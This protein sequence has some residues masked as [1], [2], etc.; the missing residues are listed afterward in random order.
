LTVGRYQKRNPGIVQ[1]YF[2]EPQISVPK[3]SL[4]NIVRA[5]G[6]SDDSLEIPCGTN[7]Q[8]A[9]NATGVNFTVSDHRYL[10]L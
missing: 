1:I 4:S 8:I 7:T 9:M 2:N 10:L 3:I 5:L 6:G